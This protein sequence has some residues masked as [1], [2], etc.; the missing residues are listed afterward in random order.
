MR[1]SDCMRPD[2]IVDRREQR[3]CD[4]TAQDACTRRSTATTSGSCVMDVRSAELTKYAA[5][6]MLATKISFMNEMANIA[7]RVGADIELVRHGIGSDPRIG[8][9]LHLSGRRL[10]RLVLSEGR[11]RARMTR[12]ASTAT[13][14]SLLTAVEAVNDEQKG[15]LFELI[16]RHFGGG[17]AGKTIRGVGLAFKPNTD[18]MREASSRRLLQQL[19]DAGAKVRA[20]DPEAT[21][22][23]AAHLRRARRP[24]R[25]AMTHRRRCRAPMRSSSSPSGRRS[26]ARDLARIRAA[27]RTPVIFD[28]RNIYEPRCGR[29]GRHR[30]LRHRPRPQ[31]AAPPALSAPSSVRGHSRMTHSTRRE[32]PSSA[33]AMSAYR[34]RSA[35]GRELPTI[36][37]DVDGGRVAQLETGQDVTGEVDTAGTRRRRRNCATA[38]TPADLRQANVFIVAVPTPVTPHKWPDL[39]PLIARQRKWSERPCPAARSSSTNRP[40]YPGATEDSCVPALRTL[41]GPALQSRFL[42]RLQP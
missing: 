34:W 32:S 40:F 10:R 38:P 17:L 39:G 33:W 4:R 22:R 2:R 12:R 7:E 16:Q 25:C 6:A 28:G 21:S 35:L 42:L 15:K 36:G 3:A 14:R 5:N 37:F 23:G 26:G 11:A 9:S 18:D 27:L 31:R 30:L 29:G 41:V 24:G 19:W 8:Y 1:S 20:Y 13:K